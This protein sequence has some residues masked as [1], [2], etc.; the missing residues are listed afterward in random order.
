MIYAVALSLLVAIF[1]LQT[2]EGFHQAD[3]HAFMEILESQA[4]LTRYDFFGASVTLQALPSVTTD[5]FDSVAIIGSVAKWRNEIQYRLAPTNS[6]AAE[7]LWRI[8]RKP[9][10]II[11]KF[12]LGDTQITRAVYHRIANTIDWDA[13]PAISMTWEQFCDWVAFLLLMSREIKAS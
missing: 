5:A 12:D 9:S 10:K 1:G 3:N 4:V 7:T 11:F 13:R 2:N 8:D 6:G